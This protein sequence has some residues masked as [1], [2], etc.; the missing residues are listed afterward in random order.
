MLLCEDPL[1]A[2]CRRN[3][4]PA[5]RP[6]LSRR[7]RRASEQAARASDSM[8]P[9]G[10]ATHQATGISNTRNGGRSANTRASNGID[11]L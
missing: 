2:A 3:A 11:T 9:P 4:V 7:S 10:Q 8:K 6:G 1:S 5:T